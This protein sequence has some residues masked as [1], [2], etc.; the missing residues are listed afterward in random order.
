M[1]V[2]LLRLIGVSHSIGW[3]IICF[4]T[5]FSAPVLAQNTQTNSILSSSLKE[6]S[7]K[8]IPQGRRISIDRWGRRFY[9]N[10]IGR[11]IY[12]NQNRSRIYRKQRGSRTYLNRR[13]RQVFVDIGGRQF[14]IDQRGNRVYI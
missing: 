14:Y 8:V 2:N 11:R 9:L 7:D 13:S 5:V 1:N 6:D 4:L 10:R 3:L 12:L